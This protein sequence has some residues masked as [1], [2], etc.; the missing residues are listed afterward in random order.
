MKDDF[1]PSDEEIFKDFYNF[2][3]ITE[4]EHLPHLEDR[5]LRCP[6]CNKKLLVFYNDDH[7]MFIHICK[8][9]EC[10]FYR[11]R[12][13]FQDTDVNINLDTVILPDY[14]D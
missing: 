2:D 7:E 14:N 13:M 5:F 10:G 9:K 11:A 12:I 1:I 8:D 6:C 4:F 3:E